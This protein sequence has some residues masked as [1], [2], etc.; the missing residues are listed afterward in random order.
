MKGI[1]P[2]LVINDTARTSA[3]SVSPELLEAKTC[4]P[5]P[6]SYGTR[7]ATKKNSSTW[8]AGGQSGAQGGQSTGCCCRG[9]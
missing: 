2:D 6:A 1:R 8:V 5:L 9:A 7:F 4:S 3:L